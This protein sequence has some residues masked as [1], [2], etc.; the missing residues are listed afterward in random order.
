[1][2]CK[3]LLLL[4][5]VGC[6]GIS[7]VAAELPELSLT[8]GY[9]RFDGQPT[10]QRDLYQISGRMNMS[11]V[12]A[13]PFINQAVKIR[14]GQYSEE[15]PAGKFRSVG[16]SQTYSSRSGLVQQATVDLRTGQFTLAARVANLADLEYPVSVG[17][18][19]GEGSQS[20]CMRVAMRQLS[21]TYWVA[22]SSS[23]LTPCA[24]E[25][26]GGAGVP[27]INIT[28]PSFYSADAV[29]E[30]V[31]ALGGLAY[32]DKAVVKITWMNSATGA[33]GTA[34]GVSPWTVPAVSLKPGDNPI[35][36]TVMDTE[37]NT[38]SDSILVTYNPDRVVFYG[39]PRSN[40]DAVFVNEEAK[41][42]FTQAI[43]TP[44]VDP[45]SVR[46]VIDDDSGK[47]VDFAMWDD[48]LLGGH[49]DEVDGDGIYSAILDL[50]YT[51]EGNAAYRVHA[52][53]PGGVDSLGP[54]SDL[55]VL[56]HI[57]PADY[58]AALGLADSAQKQFDILDASG[59]TPS[60][61]IAGLVAWLQSHPDVADAG[62]SGSGQGVW[63]VTNAGLLGGL[64]GYD[65]DLLRG[66]QSSNVARTPGPAMPSID[67]KDDLDGVHKFNAPEASLVVS[68]IS[69]SGLQS[70]S[71]SQGVV[72]AAASTA[73]DKVGSKKTLIAAPY[74]YND[75]PDDI[76]AMLNAA[77]CP[78]YDVD[79]YANAAADI[80]V[81]K[82]LHNYGVIVIASHGDTWYNGILSWWK[83]KWGWNLWGGQVVIL[84]KTAANAGNLKTYEIDLKKGRLA[85]TPG[86]A[87]AIT[88]A[89]VSY[90]N[91]GFPDSLVY[92]GS[93]RSSYNMSMAYAFLGQGA[94]T[95]FGYSEYV[96]SSFA[97]SKGINLFTDLVKNKK[98][99][100][101]AFVP[102][103]NDGQNPPAYFTM[104]G[105]N[106]LSISENEL[107]NA[108]FEDGNLNGWT[109]SGDG[110]VIP[111]LGSTGPTEGNFMGII[112][113]G[114]GYTTASGSLSQNVCVPSL[115]AGKTKM[116]LKYDWN[117]FS[118]EFLE[119]CG[120][121]YQ[122]YFRNTLGG[123][124][125]FYTYVDALCGSVSSSD[126]GFDVGGVYDTGW[127]SNALDVTSS[128][129][130]SG[131]L[132]FSAGDVG[133]SFLDSAILIDN[134]R[135]EA[136]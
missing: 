127:R 123:T 102:G 130:K 11:G 91:G 43:S 63:W 79:S 133:D 64:L 50:T 49:G 88:P 77:Q 103:Q 97:R 5:F 117:F 78:A 67:L 113:T 48:G 80:S 20:R 92:V 106:K 40:P 44:T 98:T 96:L 28:E 121:I 45:T 126:V 13:S 99:T 3:E 59:K 21:G 32:D 124:S 41:I 33:S 136:E 69:S 128:V 119:W 39:M 9:V 112:S 105:S 36:A 7:A 25:G 31:I 37:G 134:I 115:P 74:F 122:D 6:Q 34:S 38:S 58:L 51:Q 14:L 24:E 47:S 42:L 93:C 55:A 129:G 68:S 26:G 108:G 89:F 84:T 87:L 65:Q 132:T 118:E 66:G 2:R 70:V 116:R 101:Q 10:V 29:T 4:A 12:T 19:W 1:M 52:S 27:Q 17:L 76:E 83:D 82:T 60:Q 8:Q 75:E 125:L 73:K 135:F 30:G 95:Y 85:I 131:D 104:A 114:L 72:T 53:T 120:S 90:Y 71:A 94:K 22:S 81:F 61:V 18:S 109:K 100:G 15:I 46:L 86:G 23:G 56:E 62:P 110:R 35:T 16:L 107:M 54:V 111:S 57:D